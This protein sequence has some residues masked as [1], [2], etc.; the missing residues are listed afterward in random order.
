ME[1]IEREERPVL[2]L[3]LT[4][5]VCVFLVLYFFV[6]VPSETSDQ[7]LEIAAGNAA[8]TVD[9]VYF[10]ND[11][12]HEFLPEK[13]E[14]VI[15]PVGGGM[16]T[17]YIYGVATDNN[18]CED[19]RGSEPN[20]EIV[21]YRSSVAGA[22]TCVLDNNEC[23][24]VNTSSNLHLSGCDGAGDMTANYEATVDLASWVDATDI[25]T[26][27]GDN[28][29][30]WVKAVDPGMGSNFSTGYFEMS[31]TSAVEAS[32]SVSYGIVDLG[33]VSDAQTVVVTQMGNVPVDIQ[34]TAN[35]DG[36]TCSGEGFIPF[37]NV[38]MS[39]VPGFDFMVQGVTFVGIGGVATLTNV[40][41]PVRTDE[42]APPIK[43]VYIRIQM[44]SIGI[45]GVCSGTVTFTGIADLP[46]IDVVAGSG[47]ENSDNG[48]KRKR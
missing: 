29:V 33:S 44:P 21:L 7:E 27:A 24:K 30:A 4:I 38:K 26:Y 31:G 34:Q 15:V 42:A 8:P 36:M 43:D 12:L 14:G 9:A 16:K 2:Y 47:G 35:T 40:S 25:G 6:L 18:G 1:Q 11:S 20:W 17:L 5:L 23:Y 3:L 22:E 45:R 39:T 13:S 10:A 48:S 37:T 19:L 41:L 28:W 32:G 46:D